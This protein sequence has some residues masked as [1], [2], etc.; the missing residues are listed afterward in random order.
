MPFQD[1]NNQHLTP[2]DIAQVETLLNQAEAI[3]QPYLRNLS[4]EENDKIGSIDEKGKL[5]VNKVKDY[6]DGQPALSCDDVDWV[7]FEND[8]NS[9][10]AY[11][12][13]ATRLMALAKAM[14]ETKRLHDYDNYH[15]GL[16]DYE[17]SKYKDK[18]SPGLGYDTKVEELGQFFKKSGGDNA[19]PDN[20]GEA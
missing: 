3:L 18:T 2:A 9:R 19:L 6:R 16:I 13:G 8:F 11:E 14:L 5:F 1:M 10:R 15:N 20:A 7:E 17:Y 4:P 12:L